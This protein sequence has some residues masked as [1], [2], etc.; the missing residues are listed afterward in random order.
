MQLI[1]GLTLA[2]ISGSAFAQS[3]DSILI[4]VKVSVGTST[5]RGYMLTSRS[6]PIDPTNANAL[7]KVET[8]GQLLLITE[9]SEIQYPMPL[10]VA[11]AS[12][13]RS[14][15]AENITSIS[16]EPGPLDGKGAFYAWV[17]NLP[18]NAI[19]L[20]KTKPLASCKFYK[21]E[22]A[23]IHYVSYNSLVTAENLKPFCSK[24]A[25]ARPP[26]AKEKA[27]LEKKDVFKIVLPEG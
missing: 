18:P 17:L 21:Y 11:A 22:E 8:L 27:L 3:P 13:R 25:G 19:P 2:L 1:L 9:A 15:P 20:L 16:A 7:G 23:E 5:V 12:A 14:I 26:E 4:G 6:T 10:V 24:N